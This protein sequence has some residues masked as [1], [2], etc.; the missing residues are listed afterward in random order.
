MGLKCNMNGIR[1]KKGKSADE[2]CRTTGC[3]LGKHPIEDDDEEGEL[4]LIEA[5]SNFG[6]PTEA[7]IP[8]IPASGL[9][10]SS[11]KEPPLPIPSFNHKAKTIFLEKKDDL[12]SPESLLIN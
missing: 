5:K 10:L 12:K 11:E 9:A 6:L 8:K 7:L 2:L 4:D 3:D 1:P